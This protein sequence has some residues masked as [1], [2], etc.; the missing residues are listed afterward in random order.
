MNFLQDDYYRDAAREFD[1]VE[2]QHPYSVWATKAQLMAA[3]AYY[4]SNRYDDAIIALD[5]FTQLH[6]ANH[7]N[8]TTMTHLEPPSKVR[9]NV[10]LC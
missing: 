7:S 6:P 1:E 5:R 10:K 2:R 4:Q 9:F 3:Y 8:A